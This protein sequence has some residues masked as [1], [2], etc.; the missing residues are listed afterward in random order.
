M[1]SDLEELC[2]LSTRGQTALVVKVLSIAAQV[3]PVKSSEYAIAWLLM[4]MILNRI[5]SKQF[6]EFLLKL[7]KSGINKFI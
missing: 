6:L 3:R 5:E 4:K 7:N 2:I 1:S